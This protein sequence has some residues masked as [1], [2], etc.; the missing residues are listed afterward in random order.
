MLPQA[1]NF[2]KAHPNEAFTVTELAQA[3]AA[4]VTTDATD[5]LYLEAELSYHFLNLVAS[6]PYQWKSL[7][8]ATPKYYYSRQKVENVDD[9]LRVVESAKA[10]AEGR[11]SIPRGFPVSALDM[12]DSQ[13]SS[14]VHDALRQKLLE[15]VTPGCPPPSRAP[16]RLVQGN[17]AIE[18]RSNPLTIGLSPEKG[19][20]ELFI[21]EK[22]RT[23]LC[24]VKIR[25]SNAKVLIT[26]CLEDVKPG[27][28]VRFTIEGKE[29]CECVLRVSLDASDKLVLPLHV[30]SKKLTAESLLY[31]AGQLWGPNRGE[32]VPDV[33]FHYQWHVLSNGFDDERTQLA[34]YCSMQY[35]VPADGSESIVP[36][37]ALSAFSS[38][39]RP[40]TNIHMR[41][42]HPKLLQICKPAEKTDC[43]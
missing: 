26:P 27:S 38:F 9:L 4:S 37:E 16:A 34:P 5:L 29:D 7:P 39:Q 43:V 20:L 8:A 6:Q 21:S 3:S 14:L 36:E 33:D 22:I 32:A 35:A 17:P 11:A 1:V 15:F 18:I 30:S 12:T 42:F 28:A 24:T 25:S 10:T 41:C 31:P 13:T 2:L 40:P 23:N 19:I